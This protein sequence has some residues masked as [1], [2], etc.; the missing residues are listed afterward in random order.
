M[1]PTKKYIL[2]FVALVFFCSTFLTV[3]EEPSLD[4]VTY[5]TGGTFVKNGDLKNIY[6]LDK[7][8]DIQL[9]L[10]K[11]TYQIDD[12]GEGQYLL[13][14]RYLPMNALLFYPLTL[15]STKTGIF[16]YLVVNTLIILT[17]I[18]LLKKAVESGT[19]L[20]FLFSL[21][22]I[23]G[24]TIV[25][26]LNNQLLLILLILSMIYYYSRQDRWLLVGMI[27]GF[28]LFKIQFLILLPFIFIISKE[29]LKLLL[30]FISSFSS[31]L[32][33]NFLIYGKS[34]LV[35]Y[36]KFILKTELPPF[37]LNKDAMVTFISFLGSLSN[38]PE[39]NLWIINGVLY[40]GIL[41]IYLC[42]KR[43]GLELEN[44]LISAIL[45]TILSSGHA[46]MADLV[47]LLIP[48]LL[49]FIH[50]TRYLLYGSLLM[51]PLS[52]VS[53]ILP[54][55]IL[56]LILFLIGF[57]YLMVGDPGLEPGTGRV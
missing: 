31:L 54:I 47:V 46:F 51:Y 53:Y 10:I 13:Q 1:Y 28:L 41:L 11:K 24:F 40:A 56:I 2:Y 48:V 38:M 37:E 8:R 20:C 9:N 35:D 34:L 6:D 16:I 42:F 14:Y 21:S 7:Q 30:G 52:F 55:P 23:F 3:Y 27:S 57:Y 22:W 45:F 33:F 29:K 43:K 19:K 4:Y 17:S 50:K 39:I 49:G 25:S 12:L 18:Y 5:L 36:S 32:V 26:F 44:L 15:L